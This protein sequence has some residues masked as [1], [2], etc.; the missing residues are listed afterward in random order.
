MVFLHNERHVGVLFQRDLSHRE[1]SN[2][3]ERFLSTLKEKDVIDHE[4]SLESR[5]CEGVS[6]GQ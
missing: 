5:N 1:S 3:T 4:M 6:S 2:G